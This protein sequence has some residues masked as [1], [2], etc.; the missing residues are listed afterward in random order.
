MATQYLLGIPAMDV[1]SAQMAERHYRGA[2]NYVTTYEDVSKKDYFAYCTL[3][4]EHGFVKYAENS[5]GIGG[6]VFSATFVKEELVL[7][8]TCYARTNMISVSFYPGKVSE[9]LTYKEEYVQ[10]V[11]ADAKTKMHMMELRMFGNSFVFQLKNGHFIISD[12]GI[13][14]DLPYLLDYLESM[15]PEGEKPVVE[16]W[17]ITHAHGDHCG[18]LMDLFDH[19]EWR[20]RIFVDGLYLSESSDNMVTSCSVNYDF[21]IMKMAIHHMKTTTGA[22]TPIY[23]PQTGQRYYFCDLTVDILLCQEQVPEEDYHGDINTASTVAMFNIEN[24]KVMLCGDIHQPGLK[25]VIDN[26]TKEYM[27]IDFFNTN[28]HG[29][30]TSTAFTEYSTIGTVLVTTQGALPIRKLRDT[31]DMIRKSKESVKWGDG[32]AIFTFPY[33]VGEYELLPKNDWK[34]NVGEVR[35]PQPNLY[36]FPGRRFKGFIFHADAVLFNG[37]ELKPTVS[38]FLEFLKTNEVH[39]SVFSLSTTDELTKHLCVAGISDYFELIVGSDKLNGEDPYTDALF[40]SEAVFQLDH[41]HK[42][43]YVCDSQEVVD[44]IVLEGIRTLVVTYGKEISEELDYKCWKSIRDFD[45]LY[46]WFVEKRILFE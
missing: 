17:F 26:Y 36:T 28:H 9:H 12:G 15:A 4:E 42:Y 38:K 34:Y 37:D 6:T 44:R 27:C 33:T 30:N 23:R 5:E 19:P 14:A 31:R 20:N 22:E 32:T 11:T 46:P 25:F 1:P 39:M 7:T 18:A 16:A 41:P 29:F 45:E 10:N 3:L 24:Q 43:V 8:V 35:H 13:R 2:G 40:Q 21:A